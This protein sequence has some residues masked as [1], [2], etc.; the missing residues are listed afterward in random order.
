[1]KYTDIK[2]T[3][4]IS[5]EVTDIHL[6]PKDPSQI[7]TV[8]LALKQWGE[9][10][11]KAEKE[12]KTMATQVMEENDYKPIVVEAGQYQWVHRAPVTKKYS[13]ITARQYIDEDLLV[14]RGAVNLSTGVLKKIVAE[15]VKDGTIQPGTWAALEASATESF[16]KPYVMLEKIKR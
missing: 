3:N 4:T 5:G 7:A 16:T 8:L 1:M 10:I 11:A 9:E 12:L 13:F 15:Q 6:S 14:A 2:V